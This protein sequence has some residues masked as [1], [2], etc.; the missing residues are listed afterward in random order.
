MQIELC[1]VA[2]FVQFD[3][4]T[5]VV[6]GRAVSGLPA[7]VSRAENHDREARFCFLSITLAYCADRLETVWGFLMLGTLR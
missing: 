2:G 1:N 5:H 3:L 6:H 7:L 4:L